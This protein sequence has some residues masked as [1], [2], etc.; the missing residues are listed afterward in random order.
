MSFI[1]SI[2]KEQRPGPHP[3]TGEEF[4]RGE[5][6]HK[7]DYQ[8]VHS[9]P[10]SPPSRELWEYPDEYAD[11][12]VYVRDLTEEEFAKAEADHEKASKAWHKCGGVHQ[13]AGAQSVTGVF[14][15]ESD[16]EAEGFWDEGRGWTWS[17][18]TS[19][20]RQED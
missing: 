19:S 6:Q 15:T 18:F 20:I 3:T 12:P 14:F 13:I 9:L 8:T 4:V 5:I 11:E 2:P 7:Q 17:R 1:D 10:P 16:S